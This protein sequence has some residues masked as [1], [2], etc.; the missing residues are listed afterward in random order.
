MTQYLAFDIGGTNLKYALLNN[1]GKIIEH[2]KVPTPADDLAAFLKEIYKI[3]DHYQGQFEGIA[4]SVPGKV[5][6]KTNTVY[7]GGSLPYLDGVN[8]QRLVGDKYLVPVGVEND[9]KAAA[10]AELWLGELKGINNG[11]AIVL[12]TGIGGGIILDGKIWRGSH[13]QAGELSFMQTEGDK[14]GFDR[15]GCTYGSAVKMIESANKLIGNSDLK[16]GYAAFD[17]INK[18]NAE[19]QKILERECKEVATI[20]FNIQSVVDL[21]KFVI[22]GGISA[23][24]KVVETINKQYDLITNEVPFIAKMLTRPKIVRAKFMNEANIYGALYALLLKLNGEEE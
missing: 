11:A 10:L 19:A 15:F 3:A 16:D 7:F 20:I 24:P 14:S 6:T 12:G 13:F 17:A 22:G 2:D 23:Q 21:D 4:F 1:A 9:G 5:D 18:G 8:F